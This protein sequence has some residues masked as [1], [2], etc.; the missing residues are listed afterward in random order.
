M[1]TAMCILLAQKASLLHIIR[2]VFAALLGVQS[3]K[4][5]AKDFSHGNPLIYIIC[6][7]ILVLLIILT[8]VFIVNRVLA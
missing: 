1:K 2:S 4:N 8:F 7:I 3:S 5:A 6:G